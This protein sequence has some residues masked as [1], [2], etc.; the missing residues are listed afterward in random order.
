M[1]S[2]PFL[3]H[4]LPLYD[5]HVASW[6]RE[7]RRLE[8][9]DAVLEELLQWKGETDDDLSARKATAGY[10]ILPKLHATTLTG[11]LSRQTPMPEFGDLGKVRERAGLTGNKS[12]AE[13]L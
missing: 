4:T 10:I 5:L 8:G 12:A 13:L 9:G 7:E 3:A 1:P 11:H 2:L 6:H